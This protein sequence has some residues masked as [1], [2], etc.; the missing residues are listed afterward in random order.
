MSQTES[1][2]QVEGNIFFSEDSHTLQL[3]VTSAPHQKHVYKTDSEEPYDMKEIFL[4]YPH[5]IN[6]DTT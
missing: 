6:L 1:L 4:I 3:F 2:I 5:I